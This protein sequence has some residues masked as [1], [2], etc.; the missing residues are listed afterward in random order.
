MPSL[1]GIGGG[2]LSIEEIIG[3]LDVIPAE[4]ELGDGAAGPSGHGLGDGLH[5]SGA[6]AIFHL[7]PGEVGLGPI[8]RRG[9]V[10]R[11]SIDAW[12]VRP[13]NQHIASIRSWCEVKVDWSSMIPRFD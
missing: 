8:P 4:E 12:S 5:P 9:L 2:L 10:T 6:A 7:G 1:D 13:S 11:V 3:G